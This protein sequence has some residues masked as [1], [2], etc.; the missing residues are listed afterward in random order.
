ML[1]AKEMARRLERVRVHAEGLLEDQELDQDMLQEAIALS[2]EAD[3][4]MRRM[5]QPPRIAHVTRDL[6]LAHDLPTTL[7]VRTNL[8]EPGV[9]IAQRSP[10]LEQARDEFRTNAVVDR[11][12]VVDLMREHWQDPAGF[13]EAIARVLDIEEH[14]YEPHVRMEV[15]QDVLDAARRVSDYYAKPTMVAHAELHERTADI[16]LIAD[17][18]AHG[19]VEMG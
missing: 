15:G 1:D 18:I 6:M 5:E 4:M 8:Y 16:K 19:D 9:P 13:H 7:K 3:T 2:R 11:R 12:L 10:I 17:A 14:E